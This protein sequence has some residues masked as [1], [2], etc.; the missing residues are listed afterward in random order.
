MA[1]SHGYNFSEIRFF[2]GRESAKVKGG[3]YENVFLDSSLSIDNS[4]TV[5]LDVPIYILDVGDIYFPHMSGHQ[6]GMILLDAQFNPLEKPFPYYV[7]KR[8]G[9]AIIKRTDLEMGIL[10]N[11]RLEAY[12]KESLKPR[13]DH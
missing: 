5:P 4:I 8:S 2:F 11:D 12:F 9:M 3:Q 7:R 10:L 13:P 6:E 1:L